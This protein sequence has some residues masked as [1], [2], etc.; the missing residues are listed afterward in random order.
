MAFGDREKST[1]KWLHARRRRFARPFTVKN[2]FKVEEEEVWCENQVFALLI[3]TILIYFTWFGAKEGS[4]FPLFIDYG[5]YQWKV[6]WFFV[7]NCFDS[8]VCKYRSEIVTEMKKKIMQ[9]QER[10]KKVYRNKKSW[11]SWWTLFGHIN[12]KDL[13]FSTVIMEITSPAIQWLIKLC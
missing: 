8:R 1:R 6:V 11:M 2:D 13:P 4:H 3:A 12:S 5:E 7:L 10:R 9:Q